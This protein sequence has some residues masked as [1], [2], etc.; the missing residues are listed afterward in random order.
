MLQKIFLSALVVLLVL[1]GCRKDSSTIE[2]IEE[3]SE[4]KELSTT[5]LTG[6]VVNEE[7]VPLVNTVL[8]VMQDRKVIA[9]GQTDQEG[10]FT[11]RY[12]N[13]AT[14]TAF[15]RAQH[16]E[17]GDS[18]AKIATNNTTG[19]VEVT[20]TMSNFSTERPSSDSL[21]MAELVFLTGQLVNENDTPQVRKFVF[22]NTSLGVDGYAFTDQNGVFTLAVTAN[23]E[24]E[25]IFLDRFCRAN[26][27][28]QVLT[29]TDTDVELGKF[30]IDES[31]KVNFQVNGQVLGCED[32]P[33]SNAVVV[34]TTG[35]TPATRTVTDEQGNYL[36]DF[37]SCEGE[38]FWTVYAYNQEGYEGGV[39]LTLPTEGN[40]LVAEPISICV[41]NNFT[42]AV[43]VN[44][45]G[46]T[47]D[48]VNRHVFVPA[49]GDTLSSINPA[50]NTANGQLEGLL[51]TFESKGTGEDFP[52]VDLKIGYQGAT[53]RGGAANEETAGTVNVMTYS[54][55]VIEGTF[56]A[57]VIDERTGTIIPVSGSFYVETL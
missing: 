56:S 40:V 25:L 53:F 7:D 22:F 1:T 47:L 3:I 10:A 44:L 8:E 52:I 14:G 48:F 29:V 17:Y 45:A 26:K 18:W 36:L 19:E 42:Q 20:L 46:R 41:E 32:N 5:L 27:P 54:N 2:T 39:D 12:P 35:E 43:V 49:R 57:K 34:L 6:R 4:P 23:T 28:L 37:S 16:R 51:L 9:L 38:I 11:I 55:E 21:Q 30:Q 33:I 31:D 50:S 24:G 13:L 15:L